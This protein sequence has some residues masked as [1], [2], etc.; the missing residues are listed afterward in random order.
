MLKKDGTVWMAGL[1]SDGQLGI[2]STESQSTFVQV[3]NEDGTGYLTNIKSI[4]AGQYTM[5]AITND[6]EVYGW[7]ENGSGQLGISNNE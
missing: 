3:K 4:S 5:F 7:G 6:G 1:N 2:E